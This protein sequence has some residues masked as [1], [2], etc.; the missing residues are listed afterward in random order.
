MCIRD[1]LIIGDGPLRDEAKRLAKA[2]GL[3]GKTRFIP[4]V[5]YDKIP[6]YLNCLDILVLPSVTRPRLKEQFGRVL[7]EA[8]SC[9]VPVIGSDSGEIPTVIGEGGLIFPEGDIPALRDRIA[10]LIADPAAAAALGEKGR[11]RVEAEYT[12]VSIAR[13]QIEVYRRL[14]SR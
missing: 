8:M 1:R 13:R 2:L 9:S 3:S 7:V 14:L 12:W 11:R 5:A 10:A 4:A 6:E